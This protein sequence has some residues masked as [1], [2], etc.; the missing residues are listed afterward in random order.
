MPEAPPANPHFERLENWDAAQPWMGFAPRLPRNTLGRALESLSV[1][2]RNHRM[3]EVELHERTLEAYYGAF[4]FSQSRPGVA[5]ARRGVVETSYGQGPRSEHVNGCE[6]RSYPLGP[7]P[8]PGHPDPRMPAVV[9]WFE[10][11]RFFLVASESLD[12]ETLLAV[13]R[14]VA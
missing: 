11:D 12:V 14:S 7:E 8:P 4:S 5:A 13:A 1:F 6:A 9:V 3:R 2:V 10:H